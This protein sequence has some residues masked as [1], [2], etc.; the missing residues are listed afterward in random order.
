MLHGPGHCIE[1]CKILKDYSTKY[2]AQRPHDERE[3][4]SGGKKKR[5]K[6][7]QFDSTTE[8][9]IITTARDAP[10][11][12]KTKGESQAKKPK[13]DRETAVPKEK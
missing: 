7:V 9:V 2:A 5:G 1:E 10:I 8:E 4:H 12:I 3:A 13:S 11:P 6:T